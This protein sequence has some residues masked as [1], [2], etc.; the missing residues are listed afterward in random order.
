MKESIKE[1]YTVSVRTKGSNTE[2]YTVSVITFVIL[3]YYSSGSGPV[4]SRSIIILQFRF[5][6]GKN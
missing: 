3:F 6:Y 2:F 5:P 4:P 1:F